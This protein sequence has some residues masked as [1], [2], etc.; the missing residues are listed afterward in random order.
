VSTTLLSEYYNT[1]NVRKALQFHAKI[2]RFELLTLLKKA[3]IYR[4]ER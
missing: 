3:F 4:G 2:I 1:E